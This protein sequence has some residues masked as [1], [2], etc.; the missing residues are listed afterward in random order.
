MAA[1]VSCPTWTSMVRHRHRGRAARWGGAV[2]PI[3]TVVRPR[4]PTAARWPRT[5]RDVNARSVTAPAWPRTGAE[6][7]ATSTTAVRWPRT[8]TDV[9]AHSTT[10]V[11]WPRSGT[12]V[13]PRDARPTRRHHV[14]HAR[15]IPSDLRAWGPHRRVARVARRRRQVGPALHGLT[16]DPQGRT[17]TR[18]AATVADSLTLDG[19]P[20]RDRR[21]AGWHTPAGISDPPRCLADGD[22]LDTPND[23]REAE[24][25]R[26]EAKLRCR[27]AERRDEAERGHA[28]CRRRSRPVAHRGAQDLQDLHRR[29]VPAL[30]VGSLVRRPRR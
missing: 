6:L 9:N 10:A 13:S 25:H 26:R 18:P 8:R 23:H 28:E 16:S 5:G 7:A 24:L 20:P 17:S 12:D 29:R 15:P 27:E 19:A 14:V 22:T 30:R 11:R 1:T 3:R 21:H 4:G 2:P